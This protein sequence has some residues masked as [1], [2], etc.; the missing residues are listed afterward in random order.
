MSLERRTPLSRGEG[1]KRKTRFSSGTSPARG[2][3][4]A[5]APRKPAAATDPA[6][7]RNVR[8]RVR[9]SRRRD[10]CVVCRLRVIGEPYTCITGGK[11]RAATATPTPVHRNWSSGTVCH[12]R[13][14]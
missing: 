5:R 14:D 11:G 1:L 2:T 6:P 4:L 9:R 10:A 13:S 12:F 8:P 3:G 7:S